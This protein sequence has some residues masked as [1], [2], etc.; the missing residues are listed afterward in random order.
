MMA[1]IYAYV[2]VETLLAVLMHVRNCR[3]CMRPHQLVKVRFCGLM[4]CSCR[5][6]YIMLL[7]YYGNSRKGRCVISISDTLLFS[8]IFCPELASA[9]SCKQM[10][11]SQTRCAAVP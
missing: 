2:R 9:G 7:W 5:T 1:C 6:R 11:S 4:Q 3:H 10:H 8:C